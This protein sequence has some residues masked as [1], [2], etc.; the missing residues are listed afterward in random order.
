MDDEQRELLRKQ[1][2]KKIK[3]VKSDIQSYKQ[4][5]KPVSPDNAIGR[6]TRMEA[7]NSKSISAAALHTSKQQ[8][9]ELETALTMLYEA[10]FGYCKNCEEPIPLAR[11]MIM[12]EAQFCVHCAQNNNG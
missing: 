10:D 12:P 3:M 5:T 11:L 8:L 2:L 4:M 6:L 9:I 7:M 1:I